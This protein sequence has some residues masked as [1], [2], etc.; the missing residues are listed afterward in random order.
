M[1][2]ADAIGVLDKIAKHHNLTKVDLMTYIIMGIGIQN[3]DDVE[4][5][6]REGKLA[7]TI[8]QLGGEIIYPDGLRAKNDILRK[9]SRIK[10]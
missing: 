4:E 5:I 2:R 10:E 1:V 7:N 9:L 3:P 8:V 6:L